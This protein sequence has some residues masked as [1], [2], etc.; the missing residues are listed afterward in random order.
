L[1]LDAL[2]FDCFR[3]LLSNFEILGFWAGSENLLFSYLLF[4]KA[5][6]SSVK[7]KVTSLSLDALLEMRLLIG[8]CA[9]RTTIGG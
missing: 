5:K 1:T 6:T 4:F 8:C 7:R 9:A 2:R 3:V